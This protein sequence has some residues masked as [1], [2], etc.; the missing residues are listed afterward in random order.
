MIVEDD[1]WNFEVS[2][3]REFENISVKVS[4]VMKLWSERFVPVSYNDTGMTFY[5]IVNIIIKIIIINK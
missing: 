4:C 2:V 5:K 3:L 1:G